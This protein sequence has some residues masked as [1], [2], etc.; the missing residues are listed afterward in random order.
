MDRDGKLPADLAKLYFSPTRP[1]F[2]VYDLEA[3]PAELH[4]LA[5][6]WLTCHDP[7]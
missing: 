5:G 6:S 4:N 1:M 2:E 7:P 3:D